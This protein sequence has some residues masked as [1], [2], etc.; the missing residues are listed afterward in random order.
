MYAM[1][2]RVAMAVLAVST[3][4]SHASR[5]DGML[6]E[7]RRT[8]RSAPSTCATCAR[9][10]PSGK[11]GPQLCWDMFRLNRVVE[12]FARFREGVSPGRFES[13]IERG[14]DRGYVDHV[15]VRG[16]DWVSMEEAVHNLRASP[17]AAA[18]ALYIPTRACLSV[19]RASLAGESGEVKRGTVVD[20]SGR[21][22]KGSEGDYTSSVR[23]APRLLGD[24]G[25]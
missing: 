7:M 19:W 2:S 11:F 17:A 6:S 14:S 8:S 9:V 21:V 12:G 15:N 23:R 22:A 3:C 5:D 10:S 25:P 24:G 1:E 20:E 4:S 16:E 13:K 18:R